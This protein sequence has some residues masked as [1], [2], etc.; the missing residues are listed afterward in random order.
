ME[1]V[2]EPLNKVCFKC[3]ACKK[4]LIISSFR[5][6]SRLKNNSRRKLFCSPRCSLN[7]V[8]DQKTRQLISQAQ[9]GISVLS[10][11]R[12]GHIVSDETKAKIRNARLGKKRG[13]YDFDLVRQEVALGAQRFFVTNP[14]IPDAIIVEGTKVIALEIQKVRWEND[15]KRKFGTYDKNPNHGYDEVRIVWYNRA[16]VK[17]KVWVWKKETREWSLLWQRPR[18]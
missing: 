7:G 16:S 15:A 14:I 12:P 9:K 4:I 5:Y 3:A 13:K 11:G 17:M 18:E 8:R 1:S 2:L 10:R 6:L